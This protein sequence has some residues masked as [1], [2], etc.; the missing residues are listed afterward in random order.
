MDYASLRANKLPI[1]SGMAEAACKMIVNARFKQSGMRWQTRQGQNLLDLRVVLK[2][3]IRDSCQ[4]AWLTS[5]SAL[6]PELPAKAR[7]GTCQ[8]AGN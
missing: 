6:N 5:E 2:S 4:Q 1:G 7:H 8:I 3:G